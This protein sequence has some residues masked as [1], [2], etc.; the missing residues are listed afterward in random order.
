MGR[1]LAL[2]KE[3]CGIVNSFREEDIQTH[4]RTSQG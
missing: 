2:V 4:L 3:E 1:D